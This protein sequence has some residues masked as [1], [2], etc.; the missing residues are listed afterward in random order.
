MNATQLVD[1]IT[2]AVMRAEA[3]RTQLAVLGMTPEQ[4]DEATGIALGFARVGTR[5]NV[6]VMVQVLRRIQERL[7]F[8][9][10]PDRVLTYAR[11]MWG[12]HE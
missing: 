12:G 5:I 8:G 4:V 6:D 7:Q 10:A 11:R 1:D 2:E 3:E 9:E